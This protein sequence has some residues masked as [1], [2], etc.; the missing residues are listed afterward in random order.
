MAKDHRLELDRYLDYGNDLFTKKK[1]LNFD[2]LFSVKADSGVAPWTLN[3]FDSTDLLRRIQT[4]KLQLNPGL[5]QVGEDGGEIEVFAGIGRFNRDKDYDFVN[6]RAKTNQ[7]PEEQP[8]FN[9]LWGE[10]YSLSPTLNPGKRASNPMPRAKNP[11]PKGYIMAQMET[12]AKNELE[13]D[14]SVAQLLEGDDEEE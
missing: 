11:D 4:R 7:R 3:R 12:K 6:G 8:G 9:S 1:N 13:G 2:E 5:Q 14:K 10:Y